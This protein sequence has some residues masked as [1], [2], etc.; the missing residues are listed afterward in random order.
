MTGPGVY[1]PACTILRKETMAESVVMI[2]V[3]GVLGSGFSVQ[4]TDQEF[5]KKIP[6]LLRSVADEIEATA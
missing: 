3:N 2:V 5:A 1:D 6:R 4:S